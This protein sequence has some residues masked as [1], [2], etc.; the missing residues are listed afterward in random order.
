MLNTKEK[1]SGQRPKYFT[2]IVKY[3]FCIADDADCNTEQSNEHQIMLYC[4]NNYLRQLAETQ[5]IIC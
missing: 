4:E 1:K 2:C 5:T 3:Y